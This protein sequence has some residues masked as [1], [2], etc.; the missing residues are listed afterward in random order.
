MEGGLWSA[1]DAYRSH[2][3]Q[4]DLAAVGD[5]QHKSHGLLFNPNQVYLFSL[6]QPD[7]RAAL[8]Y[9]HCSVCC[10]R[11]SEIHCGALAG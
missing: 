11:E 10:F 4:L 8:N 9:S 3:S 1:C 5:F 2:S 7:D 6:R